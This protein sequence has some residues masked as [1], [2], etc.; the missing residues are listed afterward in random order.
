M[1]FSIIS[2]YYRLLLN[3]LM[4]MFAFSVQARNPHTSLVINTMKYSVFLDRHST[5]CIMQWLVLR[6]IIVWVASVKKKKVCLG[7]LVALQIRKCSS[8]TGDLLSVPFN[9]C[10]KCNQVILLPLVKSPT[11]LT[12]NRLNCLSS[13]LTCLEI[14]VCLL[15]CMCKH[16][17]KTVANTEITIKKLRPY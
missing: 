6:Q 11:V 8:C 4:Y 15:T 14:F 2:L 3:S 17:G 1:K 5:K 9:C 10:M 7:F 13:F 12:D 16:E